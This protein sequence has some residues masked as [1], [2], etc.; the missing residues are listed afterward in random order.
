MGNILSLSF[1]FRL[2]PARM[3][4]G[5]LK[6]IIVGAALSAAA[7]IVFRIWRR[8]NKGAAYNFILRKFEPFFWVNAVIAA[9][10]WFFCYEAAS[11]FSSRFWFLFWAAGMIVW[12]VFIFKDFSKISEMKE[13]MKKEE[14]FKRYIP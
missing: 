13:K 8:K 11:F 9:V 7:A 1:W 5:M 3:A 2:N 4:Q 12:L 14:E 6:V 10:L